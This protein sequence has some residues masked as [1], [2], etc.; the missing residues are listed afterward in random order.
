ML[1]AISLFININENTSF[2]MSLFFNDKQFKF[3]GN[4]IKCCAALN[5]ISRHNS[6]LQLI[7]I[8]VDYFSSLLFRIIFTNWTETLLTKI[9]IT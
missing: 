8:N 5:E 2:T 4:P 7:E 9:R 6:R 1:A 3:Y